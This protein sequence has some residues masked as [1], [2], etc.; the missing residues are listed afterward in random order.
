MSLLQQ[1][2]PVRQG[3]ENPYIQ[4]TPKAARRRTTTPKLPEGGLDNGDSSDPTVEKAPTT[5]QSSKRHPGIPMDQSDFDSDITNSTTESSALRVRV[6]GFYNTYED[7]PKTMNLC[8]LNSAV[9]FICIPSLITFSL[10]YARNHVGTTRDTDRSITDIFTNTA[11]TAMGMESTGNITRVRRKS[12]EQFPTTTELLGRLQVDFPNR[13]YPFQ[14]GVQNDAQETLQCLLSQ[15]KND[16][17]SSGSTGSSIVDFFALRT[18]RVMK[19]LYCWYDNTEHT[20]NMFL[21]LYPTESGT[22]GQLLRKYVDAGFTNRRCDKCWKEGDHERTMQLNDHIDNIGDFV[23]VHLNRTNAALIKTKYNIKYGITED[24]PVRDGV[25]DG[26][27]AAHLTA[28]V[29]HTGNSIHR[30]HYYTFSGHTIYEDKRRNWVEIN[31]NTVKKVNKSKVLGHGRRVYVLMYKIDKCAGH[32]RTDQTATPGV[33]SA[34]GTGNRNKHK[35]NDQVASSSK[36]NRTKKRATFQ[37][38]STIESDDEFILTKTSLHQKFAPK[39]KVNILTPLAPRDSGELK[40]TDPKA[41]NDSSSDN[42]ISPRNKVVKPEPSDTP[43]E[44]TEESDWYVGSVEDT[45]TRISNMI[46]TGEVNDSTL[47]EISESLPK[48]RYKPISDDMQY[49]AP[50]CNY[51]YASRGALTAL[52]DASSMIGDEVVN[53]YQN[54]KTVNGG[55]A[56]Y[57][58]PRVIQVIFLCR[59]F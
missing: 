22:L 57:P 54:Y 21:R 6:V 44:G 43:T 59:P 11:L 40:S 41:D 29:V 31:D 14:L 4:K 39:G 48:C 15:L 20:E 34:K 3:T 47:N 26:V 24:I 42:G 45:H 12:T 36:L 55:G 53:T 56:V 23:I 7:S 52:C 27:F 28:L 50:W 19:C 46:V 25:H 35:P 49:F 2:F 32:R 9:H 38:D 1:N 16:H 18:V 51:G 10:A 58:K 5:Q 37:P 8:H 13:R 33:S 30:G 17:K